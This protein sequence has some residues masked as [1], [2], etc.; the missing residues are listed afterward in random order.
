[1][2]VLNQANDGLF[3]VLIVLIRALVRFGPKERAELILS[4]GGA[5]EPVDPSHLVRTLNRWIELGLLSEEQGK[6]TIAEPYH[7]RLGKNSE[8]AEARLR[9]V[10]RAIVMLP[11]NNTR[12]W[13]SDEAKSADLSRGVAWML[14]QDVYT[15][16]AS[17]DRLASLEIEQLVDSGKQKIV[18][19]DTRWNGLRAWMPYLGFARDGT[20]WFVDPTDALRDVLSEIFEARKE[21]SGPE[22]VSR[23]AAVLPVLDGGTYRT[24][25]EAAIKESALPRPRTGIIST[26]LSRAMQRLDREGAITLA[27]RSDTEG[28]VSLTGSNGRIW[29]DVSHVL[30]VSGR[31]V[32]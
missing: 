12:F 23:A 8:C 6:I 14:A 20:K 3:N 32:R 7:S 21:L 16:D 18:Q 13:E 26:S 11:A 9:G 15:L 22:F 29:R 31:E 25:V 2:S 10:A 5:A 17:V 4:S 24:Q 19:N 28:G 30:L 27:R 1:V